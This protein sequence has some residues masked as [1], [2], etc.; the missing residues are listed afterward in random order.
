[1]ST[2]PKVILVQA[3]I[4]AQALGANESVDAMAGALADDQ[5]VAVAVE[6]LKAD[7]W[8]RTLSPSNGGFDASL[9]ESDL[10]RIARVVLRSVGGQ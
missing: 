1:M 8:L 5:I 9:F 4:E 10:E 3:V 7:G 2:H 6:A